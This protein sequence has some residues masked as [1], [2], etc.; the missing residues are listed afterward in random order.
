MHSSFI[1]F[2]LFLK[3]VEVKSYGNC[4]DR[5]NSACTSLEGIREN[6]VSAVIKLKKASK[7]PITV[8]GGTEV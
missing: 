6:T 5:H 3:G 1:L 7:C 8:T 4:S 2:S